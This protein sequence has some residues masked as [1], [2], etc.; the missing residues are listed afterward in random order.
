ML[1]GVNY[2]QSIAFHTKPGLHQ[3]SRMNS[4][5]NI[6]C[7]AANILKAHA[8][9]RRSCS[10]Q[11]YLVFNAIRTQQFLICQINLPYLNLLPV[12]PEFIL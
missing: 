11:L 5:Q 3:N 8:L 7:F 6:R 9:L 10:E 2:G 1:C 12:H 4:M